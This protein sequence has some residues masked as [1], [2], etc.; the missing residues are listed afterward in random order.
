MSEVNK[1]LIRR[2]LDAVKK[3]KSPS[4]LEEF[5]SDEHLLEH[6]AMFEAAFPFAIPSATKLD[7]DAVNIQHAY[8]RGEV[9]N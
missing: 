9:N 1:T 5:V 6:I 8:L 3:D 7:D 4:T 2:Y